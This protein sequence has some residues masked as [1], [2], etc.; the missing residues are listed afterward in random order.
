MTHPRLLLD[1]KN[2]RKEKMFDYILAILLLLGATLLAFIDLFS[3][4]SYLG[5][6]LIA[7]SNKLIAFKLSPII[8]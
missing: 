6:I 3:P 7:F 2:E 1:S 8:K 5:F 4:Y